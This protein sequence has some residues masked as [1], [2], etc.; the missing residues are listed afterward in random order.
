VVDVSWVWLRATCVVV[1]VELDVIVALKSP[2]R[3]WSVRVLVTVLLAL[4]VEE[5][6]SERSLVVW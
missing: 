4:V 2:L 1:L 5:T 6:V 3:A